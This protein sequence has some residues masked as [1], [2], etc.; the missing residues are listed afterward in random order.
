MIQCTLQ[1]SVVVLGTFDDMQF[2]HS[3]MRKS[4]DKVLSDMATW[5]P[6]LITN[7]RRL[8]LAKNRRHAAQNRPAF[9]TDGQRVIRSSNG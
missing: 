2:V 5:Q 1:H 9:K 4:G 8:G 3:R 7:G 6:P